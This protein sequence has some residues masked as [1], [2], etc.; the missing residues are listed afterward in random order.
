[1]PRG[2]RRYRLALAVA[3]ALAAAAG[4]AAGAELPARFDAFIPSP[5]MRAMGGAFSPLGDDIGALAVNPAGLVTGGGT[6]VAAAYDERGGDDGAW[7]GSL[8][9]AR[10]AW[11]TFFAAAAS[12]RRR[13]DDTVEGL[14]VA[15]AARNLIEGA[16]GSFLSVGAALRVGRLAFDWEPECPLCEDARVSRTVATADAGVMLRPLP[17]ISLAV[18]ADN[19]LERSFDVGADEVPWERTVRYGV[20]WL[21]EN[22]FAVSWERRHAGDRVTEHFGFGVRTALPLEIMAGFA[23][24]RVS[25]GIRWDGGRWRA[26]AAFSGEPQE[27]IA[28][29]VSLEVF[30]ERPA[31]IGE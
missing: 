25:G 2:F 21:H 19:I 7:T 23:S 4:A 11:G 31:R 15:G 8:A 3:C 22:R 9:A 30:F 1:M 29:S 5:R 28:V 14:F 12:Q 13:P 16:A 24:E 26:A 10:E 18:A 27:T 20:A 6:T 17:F